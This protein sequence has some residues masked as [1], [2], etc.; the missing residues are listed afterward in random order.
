[1]KNIQYNSN[2]RMQRV[3]G[4]L[5]FSPRWRFTVSFSDF[6]AN[7]TNNVGGVIAVLAGKDLGRE[8]LTVSEY[9]L[10]RHLYVRVTQGAL[11]PG[12][13]VRGTLPAPVASPW[14]VGVATLNLQ[15]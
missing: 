6:T 5:S 13:G 14:L 1:M 2:V 9:T 3:L 11:W 7:Q 12:R 4:R 15:Y 10:S 8:L